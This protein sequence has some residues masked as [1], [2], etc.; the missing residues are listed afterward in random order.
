MAAAAESSALDSEATPF[1]LHQYLHYSQHEQPSEPGIYCPLV[2][3]L[4][5]LPSSGARHVSNLQQPLSPRRLAQAATFPLVQSLE[6]T[7]DILPEH[8]LIEAYN[9]AYVTLFDVLQAIYDSLHV[10]L[11]EEECERLTPKQ[12]ARARAAYERRCEM[13]LQP[14]VCREQG[15]LR[16]DCLA[17]HILFGGL[18][19]SMEMRWSFILSLR[20]PIG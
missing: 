19:P 4:R 3:D 7:C 6:I 17:N 9:P 14:E 5:E 15:M 2:W 1:T 8:W 18:S 20:R 16:L 10:P 11:L 12:R 13:A